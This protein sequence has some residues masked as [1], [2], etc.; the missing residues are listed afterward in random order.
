MDN[1][2]KIFLAVVSLL[3]FTT[4]IASGAAYYFY[5]QYSQEKQLSG[6][7]RADDELK[8]LVSRVSQL[9][10]LPENEEPTIATVSDPDKLKDQ[11]FFAKAKKGDKV[12]IYS[13]TGKAILYDPVG[14]KILEVAP[15]NL[16]N[17]AGSFTAP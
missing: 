1:T 6:S 5:R 13:Q 2:K 17:T 3:L 15:I 9:I 12:L 4:G 7:G 16:G 8:K 10:T 11:V 14:H